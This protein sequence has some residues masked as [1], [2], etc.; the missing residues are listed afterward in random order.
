VDG[1][2]VSVVHVHRVQ[3]EGERREGECGCVIGGVTIAVARI[4]NVWAILDL[5]RTGDDAISS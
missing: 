2:L 4:A 3:G 1:L 5:P